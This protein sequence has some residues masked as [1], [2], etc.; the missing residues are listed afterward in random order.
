MISSII[1][2]NNIC[3]CIISNDLGEVDKTLDIRYILILI[4]YK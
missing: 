4:T 3:K 2:L 1:K